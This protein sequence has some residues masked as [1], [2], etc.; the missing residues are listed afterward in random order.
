[1]NDFVATPI[2]LEDVPYEPVA[3][4]P[5]IKR[6]LSLLGHVNVRLDV[7]LGAAEINIDR[8]FSLA[9]GDTVALDTELDAPVILQLDGKPIARGQLLA[10]GDCFGLKITEIL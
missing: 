1:M 9:K 7:V 10:V 5:L 3:G 2:Q 4:D 8:L 6:N